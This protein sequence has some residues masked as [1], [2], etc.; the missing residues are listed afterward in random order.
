MVL[1]LIFPINKK[2]SIQKLEIQKK[3]NLLVNSNSSFAFFRNFY[4]KLTINELPKLTF[5]HRVTLG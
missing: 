5:Y 2:L 4:K 1:I 3:I